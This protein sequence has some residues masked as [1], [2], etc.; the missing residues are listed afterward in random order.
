MKLVTYGNKSYALDNFGYLEHPS[1]WDEDF[2]E[3]IAPSLG[4]AS[5]LSSEHWL[6][7]H[8]LRKHLEEKESVPYFVTTCAELGFKLD[9]FMRLFPTGFTRGACRVAGISFKFII[10]TNFALTYEHL[11]S[12]WTRYQLCPNGYLISFDAWDETFA[13]MVA[14]KWDLPC[15]LTEAHWAVIRF[16]RDRFSLRNDVPLVY[17]TCTTCNLT[18]AA[19]HKLFPTGYRRGACRIA[20]VPVPSALDGA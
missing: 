8:H 3:G 12:I 5:G 10:E 2:A 6:I 14:S 13:N 4:V 9:A 18:L 1:M 20:G 7:I 19:F 11:P 15:G 17:E 16:I